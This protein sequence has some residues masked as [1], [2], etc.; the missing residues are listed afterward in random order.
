MDKIKNVF[1]L[2]MKRDYYNLTELRYGK[3]AGVFLSSFDT[4]ICLISL[5]KAIVS[6][7]RLLKKRFKVVLKP[8]DEP[9]R[10]RTCYISDP[11]GNLIE[12]GSF[13]KPFRK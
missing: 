13:N 1:E 8:T 7:M 6:L 9:W 12:V 4:D 11:E 5:K 2:M 3:S 10:Q